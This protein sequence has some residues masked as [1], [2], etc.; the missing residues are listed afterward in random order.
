MLWSFQEP[1]AL[2]DTKQCIRPTCANLMSF[3]G[4]C[5][6][7]LSVLLQVRIGP[8]HGIT[9]CMIG[10]VE[11]MNLRPF[12]ASNHGQ[13]DVSN[14]IR[15]SHAIF[16]SSGIKENRRW[17]KRLMQWQP[18]GRGR[19]GRPT[20]LWHTAVTNFCI[21]KGLQSNSAQVNSKSANR[22][23]PH[24]HGH[25]QYGTKYSRTWSTPLCHAPFN[26]K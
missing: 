5:F 6:V 16:L 18:D 12:M 7:E 23:T 8:L 15:S 9:V 25:F 14:N 19:G 26:V 2:P 4:S 11:S 10:M 22:P 20:H 24:T 17:V 3:S 21:W 13:T 1:F